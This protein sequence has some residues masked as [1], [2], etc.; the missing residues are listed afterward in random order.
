MESRSV[1]SEFVQLYVLSGA[2]PFMR[3][4]ATWFESMS[5]YS[6]RGATSLMSLIGSTD[7]SSPLFYS[8][9]SK[10]VTGQYVHFPGFQR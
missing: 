5:Y 9:S 7:Q 6:I 1:C 3:I 10:A 2:R 4:T 8:S